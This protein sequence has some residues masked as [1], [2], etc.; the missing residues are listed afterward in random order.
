MSQ[1]QGLESG[2]LDWGDISCGDVSPRHPFSK[3]QLM[4][5]LN[6]PGWAAYHADAAQLFSRLVSRSRPLGVSIPLAQ[7]TCS[8]W[9]RN[10]TTSSWIRQGMVLAKI[11]CGALIFKHWACLV[12]V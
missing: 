4:T 5:A 10:S 8:Y 12:R 7:G 3:C 2:S 1:S 6:V 9:V 11:R